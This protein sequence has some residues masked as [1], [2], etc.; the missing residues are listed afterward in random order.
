MHCTVHV[1]YCTVLCSVHTRLL[2]VEAHNNA[3]SAGAAKDL[4]AL[5]AFYDRGLHEHV[6]ELRVG[7]DAAQRHFANHKVEA[8]G[9][10]RRRLGR[11]RV[12]LELQIDAFDELDPVALAREL[13]DRR[14]AYNRTQ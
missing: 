8:G 3:F 2:R 13:D 5:T 4:S 7:H 14:R 1:L 12:E 9:L 11:R 6:G 10:R